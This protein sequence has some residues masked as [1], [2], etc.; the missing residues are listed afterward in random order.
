MRKVDDGNKPRHRAHFIATDTY[1]NSGRK[2]TK[3]EAPFGGI[4]FCRI[5]RSFL[6]RGKAKAITKVRE[7][8][9]GLPKVHRPK[10]GG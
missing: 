1:K 4:V 6:T 10:W 8:H 5:L 7:Y 9:L 3:D 2:Q